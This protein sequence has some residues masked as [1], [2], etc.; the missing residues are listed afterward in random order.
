MSN[1]I[2]FNEYQQ[3]NE[4]LTD[5]LVIKQR[6]K[7]YSSTDKDVLYSDNGVIKIF[8]DLIYAF[9]YKNEDLSN[10]SIIKNYNYFEFYEEL[11]NIDP[12]DA[13]NLK[14][15]IKEILKLVSEIVIGLKMTNFTTFYALFINALNILKTNTS[16]SFIA[17]VEGSHLWMSENP[18][19]YS[20]LKE[21]SIKTNIQDK[22]LGAIFDIK[23][24]YLI[25]TIGYKVMTNKIEIKK[26]K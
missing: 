21:L 22:E 10:T 8:D 20:F 14:R 24:I 2:T 16:K 12:Q 1:F 9:F 18:E 15:E 17:K 5:Y 19:K 6:S 23:Y 7:L 11:F 25:A 3:I 13:I 4:S 26:F